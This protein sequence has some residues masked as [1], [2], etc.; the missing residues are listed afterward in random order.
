M[1]RLQAKTNPP[2][3][4]NTPPEDLRYVDRSLQLMESGIL[5]G[6]LVTQ[7]NPN[8]LAD[9]QLSIATNVDVRDD[10]T[11]RSC[12]YDLLTLAKPNSLP[13]LHF[14]PYT[15]FDGS[16][17][18]VRFTRN[19]LHLW[20]EGA[21]IPITG[22]VLSGTDTSQITGLSFNNRFFFANQ[23]DVLME[24]NFNTLTYA[25]AGNAP[26]YKYWCVFDDRNVG[27][28]LYDNINPN[29]I[30]FGW[31]GDFN[32]VE[33]DPLVD[34]SAGNSPLID[35]PKDFS[36]EITGIFGFSD[37]MVISRQH[38]IWVAA[39]QPIATQPFYAYTEVKT[40][41]C[42][43]PNSIA[44]IPNGLCF[45]SHRFNNVYVYSIGNPTPEPIGDN[46]RGDLGRAIA[47]NANG[48][49][50]LFA[51][52]DSVRFE[53]I[54]NV[55]SSTSA[56]VTQWKY[57]FLTKAW[58]INTLSGVCYVDTVEFNSAAA[59]YDDLVGTYDDLIGTYDDLSPSTTDSFV[60]YGRSDGE[61]LIENKNIDTVAGE[62]RTTTIV[63]AT[64]VVPKNVSF[65]TQMHLQITAK[66]PCSI[67]VSYSKDGISFKP[68]KTITIGASNLNQNRRYTFM[69]NVRTELYTWKLECSSGLFD[70]FAYYIYH[71]PYGGIHRSG[72]A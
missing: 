5:N 6:G 34:L 10:K 55:P 4:S 64:F 65:I 23:V 18:Y 30:Q 48:P 21:W 41:G 20:S 16:T 29:P 60:F 54:V 24:I 49:E 42:D 52:Y 8:N 51:C 14:V 61:L 57:N 62:V 56:A 25:V 40:L 47:N 66:T 43:A 31:S 46:I 32:P 39:K 11:S 26:A 15:L 17:K 22:P 7:Y 1:N 70:A 28:N 13:V 27:A 38:T 63:P 9:N 59:T 69:K 53:Y 36:D 67:L 35:T 19:T 71:F 72:P 50:A 3:D 45:Y 12:G 44:P 33:F 37:V 68:Y 2:V 58:S